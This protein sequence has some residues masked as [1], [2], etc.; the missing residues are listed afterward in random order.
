MP[1][2]KFRVPVGIP[3]V[4]GTTVAVSVTAWFRFAE[5]GVEVNVV[6]VFAFCTTW[7][8]TVEVL[9]PKVASPL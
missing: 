3:A 7:L 8:R 2:K 6:V 4:L 1:S 9:V 5:L